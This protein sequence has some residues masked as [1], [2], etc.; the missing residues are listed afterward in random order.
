LLIDDAADVE[1]EVLVADLT[2]TARWEVGATGT[3]AAVID[4][5]LTFVA[6]AICAAF[7]AE[8]LDADPAETVVVDDTLDVDTDLITD[9]SLFTF[10]GVNAFEAAGP[11]AAQFAGVWAIIVLQTDWGRIFCA[12]PEGAREHKVTAG[13]RAI[14]V[15]EYV[16]RGVRLQD[17]VER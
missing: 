3:A 1:A 7:Y 11:V 6:I 12:V 2:V 17:G 16:V 10:A 5:L 4:A 9:L 15:D 14:A 8:V 13:G